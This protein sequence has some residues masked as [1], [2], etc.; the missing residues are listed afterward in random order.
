MNKKGEKPAASGAHSLEL[1]KD[2]LKG[3]SLFF[4]FPEM[5][6]I[7]RG[8]G[9]PPGANQPRVASPRDK[10]E[11]CRNRRAANASPGAKPTLEPVSLK[12]VR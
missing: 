11:N 9:F 8:Y 7:G 1:S 2:T 10:K 3:V 5:R 4:F 6:G 12:S